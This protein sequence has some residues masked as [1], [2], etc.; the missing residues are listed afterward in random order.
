MTL[1]Y[2]HRTCAHRIEQILDDGLLRPHPQ[3]LLG[4]RALWLTHVPWADRR[5]LAL[6]S[7][8][9]RC[10]R[11][12]FLLEVIEPSEIVPWSALRAG[13]NPATVRLLEAAHGARPE[14]WWLTGAEQ[15]V[16]LVTEKVR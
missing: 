1:R 9:L 5:A 2:Y 8:M 11:M 13:F 6:S 12:Q 15:R 14:Y 10:D 4:V 16:R 3:H 7:D